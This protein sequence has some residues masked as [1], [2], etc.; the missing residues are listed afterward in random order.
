MISSIVHAEGIVL[1]NLRYGE[2][3]RVAT[4]LTRELGKIGAI[5][6]GAR[7][8]KSPFGS[9]LELFNL[10]TFVLYYRA[11]RGLQ[12][13]KTGSLEREFRG[14]VSNPTRFLWGAALAEFLDR[15]L[16]EEAPGGDFFDLIAR[17]FEVLEV[18]PVDSL[19]ELFRGLQLR[20]ATHLGYS[21]VLDRC[22]HCGRSFPA[23]AEH[24]PRGAAWWFL[25]AEGG[26]VCARCGGS[27]T[28]GIRLSERGLRRLRRMAQGSGRSGD[29][30]A[31]TP[32]E[33]PGQVREAGEEWHRSEA[34]RRDLDRLVEE[35][36]R[37]HVDAY[38]G[39]RVLE[40]RADW[41]GAGRQ[42]PVG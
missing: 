36:L 14:L 9:S 31:R 17:G 30:P 16:L 21:P 7:D 25:P 39:L 28:G 3:S 32:G 2:T 15:I 18:E 37:F 11:G 6:K 1:R 13:L 22:L 8:P 23:A 24:G 20:I 5:A 41:E 19:P 34:W 38:R 42:R 10:S 26:V 27:E 40:A 35:F 29:V 33:G 12:F 4:L